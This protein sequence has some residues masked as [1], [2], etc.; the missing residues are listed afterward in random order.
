MTTSLVR[1]EAA[2]R[3]LAEVRSIDEIKLVRD[4]AEALRLYV[5]QQ[6]E[7]L[8][9]QNDIAEIKLRAERR[10][11]ELLAE[12]VKAKGA[13]Q[14]NWKTRLDDQ[15]TL[16]SLGISKFQSHRWQIEASLPEERFEQHIAKTKAN[17]KELTSAGLYRLAQK[18]KR[19]Q[20]RETQ[21]TQHVLDETNWP[22]NITLITGD[23]A[24]IGPQLPVRSFDLVITDPPYGKDSIHLYGLLAEQSARLLKPGG[25]LLAMAGQFYLPEVLNRMT[26]HL[27]YHWTFAYLTP[28]GQSPQI[29]PRK[30]NAFWKPVLW[31]VKG[32]YTGNWQGD[33]IKSSMNDKR[34]HDWGQ[35]ESGIGHLMSKFIS[36]EEDRVLDPFLGGGTTA[37]VCYRLHA[38]FVGIDIDAGAVNTTRQ[39]ILVEVANA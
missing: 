31:F 25:S 24:K 12:M 34:F 18:R 37:I 2:K 36:G 38:Q 29:W 13:A 35:S 15:T 11:G 32:E 4:Q 20:E 19:E 9:M 28:G 1:F 22:E 8:E 10:A 3:A 39:R 26:P 33:V 27:S 23:F 14:P 17:K 5:R 21:K 16:D 6:G 7:S 30:I